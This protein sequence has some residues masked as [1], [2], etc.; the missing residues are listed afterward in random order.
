MLITTFALTSA[1]ASPSID[2]KFASQ[3][4]S[5]CVAPVGKPSRLDDILV[6]RLAAAPGDL[7]KLR[8][9]DQ[10][11]GGWL[12]AYYDP[13]GERA[14]YARAA[15]LGAQLRLVAVELGEAT[16]QRQ[17]YS[18]VFTT[19]ANYIA[20]ANQ[21]VPR[22]IIPLEADG[23][24]GERGQSM[25][26]LTMPHEQTHSFQKRAGAELPRWIEEGHAEWIG[27]K[28][29]RLLAPDAAQANE[30][31]SRHVLRASRQPVALRSWGAMRVKRE[32]IMRQV[33]P[34]ERRRMEADPAYT[35][36]LTG[37]SFSF[38][39]GDVT[40]DESNVGPRYEA[41]WRTFRDLEAAHGQQAVQS[42]MTQLT[43]RPGKVDG[44]SAIQDA[45]EVL[46]DDLNKRL[47]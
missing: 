13:A 25:I 3:A 41:S 43:A 21:I 36:P 10:Q 24:M 32:A 34:E 7:P 39:P 28:I 18:A 2:P 40:G 30:E 1:V 14:A 19:D 26:V 9:T 15:C 20:P 8:I 12:L 11:S 31:R 5:A 33:P 45:D 23:R 29:S 37:R 6:E 38:G 47:G 35:A 4:Q 22:W 16:S 44:A 46:H 42:W 27:R 17:W